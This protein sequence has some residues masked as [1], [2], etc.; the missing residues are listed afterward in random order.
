[1]PRTPI[2]ASAGFALGLAVSCAPEAQ[3]VLN[4]DH[5]A[6]QDGDAWCAIRYSDGSR[7]YCA[8]G[9]CGSTPGR[10]GCVEQRPED[11]ACYSPCGGGLSLSEDP[12]C[13]DGGTTGGTTSEATLGSGS[14]GSE[15]TDEPTTTG[16]R[17]C[18][19]NTDC[20]NEDA[21]FCVPASGE[22]VACGAT[23]DPNAA[24]ASADSSLPV[25]LDDQCV[26]CTGATP[27]ACEG[28]TPVCDDE[29]NS[30]VACTAHAQC[31]EAACNLF[32]GACLPPDAVVHVGPGQDFGSLMA[33]LDSFEVGAEGTIVVH[34]GVYDEAV[35]LSG[36]NVVAF[37]AADGGQPTW[38]PP[39][40]SSESQLDVGD[41]TVLLDG[42]TLSGNDAT[43][44]PA[45]RVV[46][47][48]VWL[49]RSRIVGNAGGAIVAEASAEL[50]T[51][52]AFLGGDVNDRT[53]VE[54]VGTTATVLY[55]T[56]G[57]GFGS[58]AA[59]TC[60]GGSTVEIR[61][62]VLVAR[63]NDPEL[64]CSGA[65][66]DD[67]ATEADLGGSNTALGPMDTGWF[68]DFA[69]GDFHLGLVPA[70]LV[71]AGRWQQGDPVVDIDGD[72]RPEIDGSVDVPGADVP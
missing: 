63:T 29:A 26:E 61:N 55:S 21:P 70:A 59:L 35:T 9:T 56:L 45:L 4:A 20:M 49:D 39:G 14:E 71:N 2:F 32:T 60:D 41:A 10:D 3:S 44:N 57:S 31:G 6:N 51:R 24:C 7:S 46:G 25:C 33:A 62:S 40:L 34:G 64:Q 5:C 54:L 16:S 27:D 28:E 11:D 65:T 50:V 66:V 67:S 37:R 52:N 1:M 15:E 53:S 8:R 38:R 58:A 22:C 42:L 72:L 69:G 30:C 68:S 12:S 36:G 19:E 23:D 17:P 48:R 43:N 18:T 13:V 47:G